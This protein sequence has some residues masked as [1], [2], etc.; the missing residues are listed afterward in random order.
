[1]NL[2]RINPLIAVAVLSILVIGSLFF[3]KGSSPKEIANEFMVALAKG[4]VNRLV[5]LSYIKDMPPD[6]LRKKWEFSTQIAGPYYQFV[7]RVGGESHPDS[8]SASAVIFLN[9]GQ[10]DEERFEIPLTKI[11][12]KWLVDVREINRNMFPAMPR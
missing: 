4:D 10:G 5:A 9:R 1:M 11:G 2:R 3:V 12:D 7:W 6:E 8:T